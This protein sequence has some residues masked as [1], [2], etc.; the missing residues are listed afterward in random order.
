MG[1]STCKTLPG[2]AIR[3]R[4]Q[5]A[6]PLLTALFGIFLISLSAFSQGNQGTI[7][8]G[9]FDQTGGAIAGAMVTVTDTARG[10][11]RTLTTDD[12]GQYVAASLNPGTYTVRA[13][14]K[15]FRSVEHSGVL[16]QVGQN[17]RVDL[18]VQPGEQTQTVTVTGELP[19][20]NT[21]DATL[22]GTVSNQ[23]ILSLPLNGRN[24]ERLLQLRPGVVTPVGA[25]TGDQSTNGMRTG[26][27]L[28][29][30]EGLSQMSPST[31]A[32]VLN[33]S[34]RTG[35]A[36]SLLP[37]DAIQE[38]NTEQN[39]KAEY[40]WEP[41][42]VINVGV[43]SGTNSLHGA[44]YAFGRDAQATDAAN[45][46]STP[47]FPGATPATL[48]QFGATAGGRIIKDKLFWF[49]GY[50]G[51]RTTLGDV[52]VDTIPTDIATGDATTSMVD[53]CNALKVAGKTISPLSAQLAGLNTATCT[54]TPS[55]ST[56]ENLFPFNATASTS[57]SPGLI[58]TGPLNN[59]FIK[60]DYIVSEHNHVSGMYYVSKANQL[61]SYAVGQLEPQWRGAV[62]TDAQM[63]NAAW[64]WTPSSAW[65]N[66]VRGG[67]AYVHNQTTSGD[68]NMIPSN[69]YPQ[70]YGFNT[71]VTNPLYGGLPEIDITTFTGYLG[72]G[73]R[74]GVR[75]PEGTVDLVD[76]VSHLRGKHAFKFGFE[77]MDSIYDNNSYNQ[78]NGEIKFSTLQDFL[79]GNPHN[80][81]IL[82]GNPDLIARQ[83]AFAGFFQ[84]D[85]RVTT[86]VTLNLGL[87][88]EYDAPPTERFNYIGNFDPNVT[89]NTPAV[90]QAGPGAPLKNLYNPDHKDFSPRVGVAWDVRGN[91]K[92]VVRAAGSL[93]NAMLITSEL[94]NPVPFGANFPELGINTSGTAANAH[95]PALFPLSGGQLTWSIA[96]PVFPGNAA[97]TNAGV[98]YT[99][100]TCTSPSLANGPGPCPTT[101]VAP[102]FREPYVA[103]W[104]LD[105]QRAITNNLTMDIAYVG[106][107]GFK[108][109]SEAD[110]NQPPIGAGWDAGAVSACLDPTAV[111]LYSN[112]GANTAAEV[113]PYSSKFPY[114]S[115]IITTGN[116][117]FSNY[118][119]L[120]VTVS[121]RASHGL[122]FLAG[123]TYSHALDNQSSSSISQSAFPLDVNNPR[124][125]YGSTDNDIR[126]R[127]T[128]APTY[129]IPGMKAPGQMLQGWT[130]SGILTLQSGLPWY[131]IDGTNDFTGTGEVNAGGVQTWNYTGPTS[132]FT[133][134]PT[135]IPCFGNLPD[136]SS[137]VIPQSCVT[138]AQAPYAGNAQ[139]QQ[140][141]LASLT[142]SGCYMQ[143]GGVL[144]PPAYGTIGNASR[145][146]FRSPAYYNVD[147]S[148]SKL[149]KFRERYSAQFRVEVFNLFNRA[150]FSIPGSGG[151]QAAGGIDPTGGQFGCS[152]LTPDNANPVLGSGGPRHIQFGLKLTY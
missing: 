16:V 10:V 97:F 90:L 22:G 86:R 121:E 99:G 108:Q 45:Y 137:A 114:L 18:T 12:A 15:G 144:T 19:E 87:R 13:E 94:L 35:D 36:S 129:D 148:V 11:S 8:G 120:E 66:D 51:L 82:I 52:A 89:G 26:A 65:V 47:A 9:I 21:T 103:S 33:A 132:A 143:N 41:G 55:S 96:G 23:A 115:Q 54:V 39:P 60:A 92:T 95:S 28:T 112:C 32:S 150:D 139:L 142:N 34:Y 43:K 50:E 98:T 149:W 110:I 1:S 14:A 122:S 128:F 106:N 3:S 74:T 145:N 109:G 93:L 88:Y 75:G 49:A 141:A 69:P 100:L 116:L 64:T 130:L 118:N 123:Y 101:G 5:G 25:G 84:D 126:H 119:A 46:F 135:N 127:F 138:A 147:F 59:G 24:F 105:I 124:L 73:K 131:P 77:Y 57:F 151:T 81:K 27:D 71:G 70:G 113:G 125:G 31:G 58:T 29:M 30:I 48:E 133:S 42:S 40:G 140:L 85:W 7:Q 53:A 79:L 20:I 80:G 62:P 72:A 117:Y 102:N 61:V 17:I 104:N 4:L 67:Y 38:F 146:L 83:H 134:G 152:C 63:F 2:K 6:L 76:N 91:G 111:P 68:V 37:I 107:H 56:F 136:C 44:A 78:A